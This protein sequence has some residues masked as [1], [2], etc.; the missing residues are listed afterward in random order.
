MKKYIVQITTILLL[1]CLSMAGMAQDK[2]TKR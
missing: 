2:R 1:A